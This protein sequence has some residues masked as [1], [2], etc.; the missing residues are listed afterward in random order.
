MKIVIF[1]EELHSGMQMYLA[2][3]NHFD[4]SIADSKEDL[5][6]LINE[7]PVDFAF[8]DLNDGDKVDN[9]KFNIA[10]ELHK[11]QPRL[12]IIGILGNHDAK[13]RKLA[14]GHG[15]RSIVTRP[16]KNRELLNV[17]S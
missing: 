11:K 15:I 5:M 12:H 2:L 8:L 17:L 3:S 13:V 1:N 14:K 16:I 9:T 4:V 7:H 6:R 10:N